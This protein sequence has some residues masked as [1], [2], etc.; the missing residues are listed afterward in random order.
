MCF[1]PPPAGQT[2]RTLAYVVDGATAW[3]INQLRG[4]EGQR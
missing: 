4:S 1:I 3:N 2:G